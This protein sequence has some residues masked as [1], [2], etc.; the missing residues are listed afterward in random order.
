MLSR[1]ST[2]TKIARVPLCTPISNDDATA[3]SSATP[4]ARGTAYPVTRLITQ[5]NAATRPTSAR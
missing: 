4:K 5:N 1:T 3:W 2:A